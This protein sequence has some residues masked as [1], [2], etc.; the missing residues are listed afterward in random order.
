MYTFTILDLWQL[1]PLSIFVKLLFIT[2]VNLITT[3]MDVN[4]FKVIILKK[5]T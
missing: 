2:N 4:G 3:C 5:I 1:W